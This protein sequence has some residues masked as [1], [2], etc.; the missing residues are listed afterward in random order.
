[1]ITLYK[2]KKKRYN[3][4]NKDIHDL[5]KKIITYIGLVTD[6]FE[7]RRMGDLMFLC[8]QIK[9]NNKISIHEEENEPTTKTHR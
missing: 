8:A 5:E 6:E 2:D 9:A 7:E 4:I 3:A 1:M